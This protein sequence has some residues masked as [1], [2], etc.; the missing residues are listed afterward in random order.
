MRLAMAVPSTPNPEWLVFIALMAMTILGFA[1]GY[2]Q[3][4]RH[5]LV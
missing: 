3:V 5:E 4:V 1:V 2:W